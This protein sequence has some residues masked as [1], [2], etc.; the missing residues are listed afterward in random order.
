[1]NRLACRQ[2]TMRGEE[3]HQCDKEIDGDVPEHPPDPPDKPVDRET[4]LLSIKLEGGGWKV[5]LSCD[6]ELISN[7][8]GVPAPSEGD[9]EARNV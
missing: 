2:S 3:N 8:A 1:M 6:E 4:K 9:E 7:N 5:D